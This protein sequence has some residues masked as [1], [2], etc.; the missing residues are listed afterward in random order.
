[1]KHDIYKLTEQY[2]LNESEQQMF[3]ALLEAA[4]QNT[5]YSVREFA[6][7]NYV[8]PAALIR[9]SKK[10]G[11]TGY[12][13][14]V[15]RLGFLVQ[16]EIKNKNHQ[17]DITAFISEIPSEKITSFL[18]LIKKHR[19]EPILIAGTG[20]CAPLRDFFVRKLLVM[21]YC[22]IG[23]NSYEV[24]ESNAL[25]AGMVIAISKSGTT[26]TIIKPV[27]DACVHRMEV[28][29]FTGGEYSVISELADPAFVLL[30]DKI[31]DDRNLTA[32]YFYARVLI[33][34]EYLMDM[35]LEM[36]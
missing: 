8:S 24:Y 13:D 17:S 30:D 35:T 6:A 12:T 22:A 18:E 27:R 14:M 15:Y 11:Y 20:F 1:M 7:R 32:N 26:D 25:S 36:E 29:A 34:F 10:M 5:Q 4:D 23:S 16:N 31:L 19:H 9:L 28:A 3:Q 2:H 21:G 33:L